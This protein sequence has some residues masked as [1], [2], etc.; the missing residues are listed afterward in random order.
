MFS[1]I[2]INKSTLLFAVLATGFLTRVYRHAWR[3]AHLSQGDG[4]N[5]RQ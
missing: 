3:H 5:R 2:K 4:L 1:R